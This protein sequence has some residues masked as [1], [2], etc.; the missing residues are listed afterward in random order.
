[1]L[2]DYSVHP[3]ELRIVGPADRVRMIEVAET[4]PIDLSETIAEESFRTTAFISDPYCRFDEDPSV[5]VYVR[6]RKP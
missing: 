2:D 6:A 4:D 5:T 1:M 3:N